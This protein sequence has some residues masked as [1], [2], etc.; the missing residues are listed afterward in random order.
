MCV[1]NPLADRQPKPKPFAARAFLPLLERLKD[2]IHDARIE[3]DPRIG[4]LDT[5]AA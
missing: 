4:H 2:S 1:D 3:P 5:D